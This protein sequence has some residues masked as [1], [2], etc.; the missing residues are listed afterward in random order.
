MNIYFWILSIFKLSELS[1]KKNTRTKKES[2]NWIMYAKTESFVY[3][4]KIYALEHVYFMRIGNALTLPGSECF[5]NRQKMLFGIFLWKRDG[6]VFL[7]LKVLWGMTQGYE[8]L[9]G[10]SHSS[11][12]FVFILLGGKC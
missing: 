1:A 9:L 7:N 10:Y 4:L 3:I 5:L 2:P 11:K 8:L 6:H 12:Q